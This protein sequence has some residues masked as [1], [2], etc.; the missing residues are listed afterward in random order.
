MVTYL[1][2]TLA[3]NNICSKTPGG[4]PIKGVHPHAC[5]DTPPNIQIQ[6]PFQKNTN[7]NIAI[8]AIDIQK[9]FISLMSKQSL[10]IM[11]NILQTARNKCIPIYFKYWAMPHSKNYTIF[12]NWKNTP[13]KNSKT[14]CINKYNVQTFKQLS[15]IPNLHPISYQE[16]QRTTFT[17]KYNHIDQTL[18]KDLNK[19]NINTIILIGGFPEHCITATTFALFDLNYDIFILKQAI[20]P[21]IQNIHKQ[22]IQQTLKL[23][24]QGT[25]NILNQT[26]TLKQQTCTKQYQ[27]ANYNISNKCIQQTW[28]TFNSIKNTPVRLLEKSTKP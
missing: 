27:L 13:M 12:R 26:P 19:L 25:A 21:N 7:R 1:I 4:T 9:Q 20:F 15:F 23:L 10:Q 11:Q 8:F 18:L 22:N 16:H 14:T 2:Y 5:W 17:H 28:N 24:Q 6:Q 3:I